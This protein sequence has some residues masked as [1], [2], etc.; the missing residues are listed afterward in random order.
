MV[1][2]HAAPTHIERCEGQSFER[3]SS[4]FCQDFF[5]YCHYS[6][7]VR[8]ELR[9]S[10]SKDQKDHGAPFLWLHH[11]MIDGEHGVDYMVRSV[12]G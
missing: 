11:C 6:I 8:V 9:L 12:R 3:N 7:E 2:Y 4:R 1:H 10:G 5:E